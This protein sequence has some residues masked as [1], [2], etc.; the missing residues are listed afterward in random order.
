LII[1]N[2]MFDKEEIKKGIIA[3]HKPVGVTSF[4]IIRRLRILTGI[5]KIG[6]A[7]TLDPLAEGILVVGIGRD[8]CKSLSENV[9]KEKEYLAII[10]LGEESSTDDEEGVKK[11]IKNAQKPN[12]SDIKSIIP[13][14][15]GTISQV[16]PIFSSIKVK[17]QRAYSLAR[18]GET[19]S[20]KSR[21]REIKKI[22][23]LRY[24]WPNLSLRV[25]TGPGVYIRALARDI[26]RK[27][28]CGGY[29]T[30][31]KRIRVGEFTYREAKYIYEQ[32]KN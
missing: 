32:K 15:Q 20:L 28:N 13:K 26:G 12:L 6:H 22:E 25:V 17:G 1:N 16:P 8:A 31:L 7:G 27:L 3:V 9:K 2:L 10:K 14:F 4:D 11:I 29:L 30:N 5:R 21:K 18:K 19:V 23:I 24:K